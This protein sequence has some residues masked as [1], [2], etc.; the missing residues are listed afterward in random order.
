MIKIARYDIVFRT[1][2]G[3][4]IL[5]RDHRE[6]GPKGYIRHEVTAARAGRPAGRPSLFH[7]ITLKLSLANPK[8]LHPA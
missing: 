2:A 4:K 7:K 5:P 8:L 6:R 1:M 3:A